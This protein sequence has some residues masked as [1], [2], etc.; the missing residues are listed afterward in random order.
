LPF[1]PIRTKI[2][3]QPGDAGVARLPDHF[4]DINPK[5]R[6]PVLA[7]DDEVVT[8]LPA[9]MLA[10]SALAPQLGLTGL[11]TINNVRTY[12]WLSFLSS[13]LHGLGFGA[14]W[15]PQRFIEE[16]DLFPKVSKRGYKTVTECYETI[17][18]KLVTIHSVGDS[19][20]VTDAFMCVFWR[21]GKQ[22][23]G[24]D[25]DGNYPKFTALAQSVMERDSAQAAMKEEGLT[26]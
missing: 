14:V 6:V 22:R 24:I 15:R 19:F 3:Q 2:E 25:M 11:S 1:E 17:E 16:P 10:I 5:M 9:I 13:T 18:G 26:M 20:T 8:E 4:H 21:W 23:L 12:E 7:I